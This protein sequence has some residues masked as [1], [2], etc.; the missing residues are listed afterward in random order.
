[1]TCGGDPVVVATAADGVIGSI[2]EAAL[3]SAGIP[4]M[5][6]SAGRGWLFPGAQTSAGPVELLVPG[7]LAEDARAILAVDAATAGSDA[8]R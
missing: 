3:E 1:M 8:G 7:A 6:R 5:V 4:V 2:M